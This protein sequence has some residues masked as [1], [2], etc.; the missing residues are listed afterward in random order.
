MEIETQRTYV[1]LPRVRKFPNNMIITL[2]HTQE[3]MLS[4]LACMPE[5]VRAPPR[6]LRRVS[7]IAAHSS[8]TRAAV[9][10]R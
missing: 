1:E 5:K 2:T 8:A 9:R 10:N 3:A 7:L 4:R 6:F